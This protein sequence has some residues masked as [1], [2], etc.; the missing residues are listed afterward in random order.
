[1]ASIGG[2]LVKDVAKGRLAALKQTGGIPA[3]KPKPLISNDAKN[4]KI[5][6]R[7]EDIPEAKITRSGGR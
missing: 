7:Y 6:Q 1:M 3:G 5:R 2:K 4:I